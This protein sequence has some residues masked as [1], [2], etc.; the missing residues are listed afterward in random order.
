MAVRRTIG[1]LS[2][3]L[4]NLLRLNGSVRQLKVQGLG[5]QLFSLGKVA[6]LGVGAGFKLGLAMKKDLEPQTQTKKRT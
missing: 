2:G 4:C 6:V 5:L 3:F 1:C